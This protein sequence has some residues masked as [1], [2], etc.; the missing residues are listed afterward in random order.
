MQKFCPTAKAAARPFGSRRRPWAADAAST[1]PAVTRRAS[2]GRFLFRERSF[3]TS[4]DLSDVLCQILSSRPFLRGGCDDDDGVC[5]PPR[6]DGARR[7]RRA[8]AAHHLRRRL[9]CLARSPEVGARHQRG[10]DVVRT[11]PR[12]YRRRELPTTSASPPRRPPEVART[13]RSEARRARR[14]SACGHSG[15]TRRARSRCR[16]RSSASVAARGNGR[17]DVGGVSAKVGATVV[18]RAGGFTRGGRG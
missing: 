15:R 16:A 12:C 1:R 9:A 14:I 2:R 17:W 11:G 10:D 4:F 7:T 3:E 13:R 18:L 8:V 6:V 5:E